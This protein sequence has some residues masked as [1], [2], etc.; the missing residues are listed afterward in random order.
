M[1]YTLMCKEK[2]VL[3]FDIE[4]STGSVSKVQLLEDATWAPFGVLEF[5]GNPELGLSQYVYDRSISPTREDLPA[6]LEAT[7][8][9]SPIELA[10]RAG[11]FSLFDPYWYRA[12]NSSLTWEQGNFFEN[13]WDLS[14]ANAILQQDY[15]ALKGASFAT[16][17]VTSSGSSRKAWVRDAKGPRLLKASVDEGHAS[18]MGEVLI[19]HMLARLLPENEFVSYELVEHDGET[20]SASR[21]I[22]NADEELTMAWQALSATEENRESGQPASALL[23]KELLEELSAALRH[24]GIEGSGQIVPKMMVF[25]HLAF[26]R[27]MHPNN[28]G[29]IRTIES[30]ALRLAPFFDFDRTFGFTHPDKMAWACASPGAAKLLLAL[31]FSNLDPA[32]DYSWYDSHAL[33]GFEREIERMVSACDIA[34]EGYAQLIANMFVAQRTYV[35]SIADALR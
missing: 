4:L 15:A 27:D 26:N 31:M 8:A 25:S 28:L 24:L 6:I 11:G 14:F 19:S 3:E 33:D 12:R 23:G 21:P 10:F 30:G 32:W 9:S 16:P 2:E 17:D 29:V 13:D 5:Q 34:P 18:V 20:Y 22:V 1:L 7:G 35:N